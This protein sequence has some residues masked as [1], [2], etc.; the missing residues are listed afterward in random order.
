MI[1]SAMYPVYDFGLLLPGGCMVRY[2]HISRVQKP[3]ESSHDD[4][5]PKL[6][7]PFRF[8]ALPRIINS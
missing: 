4:P 7:F 6:P 3:D 1:T 2:S 5:G 8:M